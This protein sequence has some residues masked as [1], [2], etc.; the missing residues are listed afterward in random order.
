MARGACPSDTRLSFRL[1]RR[2]ADCFVAACF[3]GHFV[4]GSLAC[5]GGQHQGLVATTDWSAI[6]FTVSGRHYPVRDCL[7]PGIS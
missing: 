3:L 1:D 5:R 7:V 2:G 6:R 4:C